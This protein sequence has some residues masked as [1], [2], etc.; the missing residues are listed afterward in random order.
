MACAEE[1]W[2]ADE[3]WRMRLQLNREQFTALVILLLQAAQR[4]G[5]GAL[6][7]RR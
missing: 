7:P 2:I 6:K 1:F 4:D 5:R 3:L